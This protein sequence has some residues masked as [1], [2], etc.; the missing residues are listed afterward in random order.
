MHRNPLLMIVPDPISILEEALR[1]S[2][3]AYESRNPGEGKKPLCTFEPIKIRPSPTACNG[4]HLRGFPSTR[5]VDNNAYHR[6]RKCCTPSIA[7]NARRCLT[8][9]IRPRMVLGWRRRHARTADAVPW[10]GST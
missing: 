4:C 5:L 8:L 6:T 7:I 1:A 2:M 3:Y 10:T 9:N